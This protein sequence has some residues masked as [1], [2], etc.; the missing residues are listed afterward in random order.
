[1]ADISG[2]SGGVG[3]PFLVLHLYHRRMNT[4]IP[5]HRGELQNPGMGSL[6]ANPFRKGSC[7]Q[8]SGILPRDGTR[9]EDKDCRQNDTRNATV[10]F[11]RYG[12]FVSQ[13]T[14]AKLS[15]DLILRVCDDDQLLGPFLAAA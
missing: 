8:N 6:Y 7:I 11:G 14:F 5:F 10:E 12:P 3:P 1:M 15:E 9:R 13:A 4:P 2:S